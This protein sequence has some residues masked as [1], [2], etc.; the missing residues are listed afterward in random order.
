MRPSCR[1]LAASVMLFAFP[2]FVQAQD[3]KKTV[4]YQIVTDRFYDGS[5]AND[6]PSQSPGLYDS[7]AS[8][9]LAAVTRLL[10][11]RLIGVA[12]C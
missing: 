1:V 9:R 2:L 6:N 4:I 10:N 3:Y 11:G 8:L 12:T 7:K 5:T